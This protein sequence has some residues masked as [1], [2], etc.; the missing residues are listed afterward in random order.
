MADFNQVFEEG[1]LTSDA[2]VDRLP[3]GTTVVQFC[4][5][6]NE[7]HRRTRD[8]WVKKCSFFKCYVYGGYA[9]S[10]L[11][12][13]VKSTKVIIS[14]KLEQQH[15][16]TPDGEER[17]QVVIICGKVRVLGKERAG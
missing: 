5:A 2:Q 15:W 16:T 13:L 9:E 17:A 7:D 3:N 12:S 14:G 6:C 11:P 1:R 4:I 8:E 10:L